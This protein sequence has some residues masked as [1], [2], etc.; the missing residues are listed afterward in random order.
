MNLLT[1]LIN[2]FTLFENPIFENNNG[3]LLIINS[4]LMC[5]TYNIRNWNKNRPV[6]KIRVKEIKEF[7]EKSNLDLIP[8]IIYTWF[9]NDIY[10]IYDGL[11]RYTALKE[12]N[13]EFK[14]LMYINYSNDENDIINDFVN[15]NKSIPVPSIYFENEQ[16]IKKSICQNI[17]DQLCR[18]YPQFVSAARKPHVYNFNRD[19]IVEYIST[20]NINFQTKNIDKIVYKILLK[21]NDHAKQKLKD[22]NIIYP[23][24]CDKY[25]F[26]L[27]YLD[28]YYIKEQIENSFIQLF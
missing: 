10:Y 22:G 18:D 20:F 13:K 26:Y 25:N 15:I 8:G 4:K 24:K 1:G 23:K 3:K 11:H 12:L 17:A 5:N 27:F 21:L 19:I 6:D 14:I 16:L 2:K 28:K 7:Y 9:N